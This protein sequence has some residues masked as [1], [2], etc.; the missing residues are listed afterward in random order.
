LGARAEKYIRDRCE[1]TRTVAAGAIGIDT[2]A[3]GQALQ[4]IQRVFNNVVAC[5]TPEARNK[6]RTT[7]VVV[8]MA[9]VRMFRSTDWR[10]LYVH[11]ISTYLWR[12]PILYNADFRFAK[13]IFWR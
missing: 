8:R 6:A 13:S 2:A 11:R 4:R 10:P 7:S 3:M 5:R 1:Q 12:R 9:P